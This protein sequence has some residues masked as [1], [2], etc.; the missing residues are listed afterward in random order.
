MSYSFCSDRLIKRQ[1]SGV[2]EGREGDA[3]RISVASA[4]GEENEERDTESM[5]SARMDDR[6]VMRERRA[7]LLEEMAELGRDGSANFT[8]ARLAGAEGVVVVVVMILVLAVVETK[9]DVGA[10]LTWTDVSRPMLLAGAA[11]VR[12]G[13]ASSRWARATEVLGAGRVLGLSSSSLTE[14]SAVRGAGAAAGRGRW[15]RP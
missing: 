14:R 8:D 9:M 2:R 1:P 15:G 13:G 7:L 12:A 10:L 3:N 5:A 6:R 11:R 4:V